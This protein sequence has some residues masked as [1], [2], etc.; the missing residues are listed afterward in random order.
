M[1]PEPQFGYLSRIKPPEFGLIN[2]LEMSF[3][4]PHKVRM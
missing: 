2:S 4:F 3:Q 1:H